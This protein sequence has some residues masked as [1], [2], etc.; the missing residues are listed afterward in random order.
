VKAND[1]GTSAR[2]AEQTMRDDGTTAAASRAGRLGRFPLSVGPGGRHLV[3][4]NGEPFLV[5]GDSGWEIITATKHNDVLRYLDDRAAKGF[6]ALNVELI[7]NCFAYDP[8]K[9]WFGAHP[10]TVPGDFGSPNDA[11]FDYAAWVLEAARDRGFLVFLVVA[12]LGYV[13]P[14]G[15][16]DYGGYHRPQGFQAEVLSSGL[17]KCAAYGRYVGKRFKDLDNIVWVMAGDRCPG[18][19]LEHQRAMAAGIREEHPGRLFSAH[20][21]PGCKIFDQFDSDPWIT[22][23]NTYS[24]GI[25]HR[26]LLFDYNHAPAMPNVMFESTYENEHNASGVQLRRQAWWSMLCGACGQVMGNLPVWHFAPGWIGSLDSPMSQWEAVL[27]SF[28]NT[29]PW[30]DLVPDQ[31]HR[32]VT[33]GLG[34][35]HGLDFCAAAATPS[36]DLVLAYVPNPRPV[37]VNLSELA[38]PMVSASWF[39]PRTGARQPIGVF[40]N[41]GA[42]VFDTYAPG[43]GVLVLERW[44]GAEPASQG[45]P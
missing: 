25:V 37:T 19:A 15:S 23:N 3:D 22:V 2:A 7:D 27:A 8:P 35:H 29:V 44:T 33:D 39:D 41:T 13:L 38:G 45:N 12:T 16:E 34:E 43:D 28:F 20:M 24:Y 42:H 4:R 1:Q 17:E 31:D 18:E 11:Y 30:W 36:G 21:H 5:V 26:D 10:F 6:T 14:R 9:N 40:R 32:I